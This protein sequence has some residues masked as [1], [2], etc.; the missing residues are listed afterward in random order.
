MLK[1]KFAVSAGVVFAYIWSSAW[2][3]VP[4]ARQHIFAANSPSSESYRGLVSYRKPPPDLE[5]SMDPVVGWREKEI[6]SR[7]AALLPVADEGK[8]TIEKFDEAREVIEMLSQRTSKKSAITVEHLLR[9]VVQEKIAGNRVVD[10]IDMKPMYDALIK[11]WA[12]SGEKGAA[13]RAEEILD[14]MQASYESGE[15]HL[16]PDMETFNLVLFAYS[17][18]K[19]KDTPRQAMRIL[20]K[21][22]DL[23]AEG[24]TD[25]IPNTES[26]S[27]V[28]KAYA[29]SSGPNA[30]LL[31][32]KLI[33][34]MEKLSD[35]GFPAVRPDFKCHNVYL[36]A[37]LASMTRDGGFSKKVP[38]KAEA[39]LDQMLQNEDEEARPDVWSWNMVIS[40]WSKSG[41][42]EMTDRAESLVSRIE[43]YHL[44]CGRSEK[45]LPNTNTYNCLIA[46][47][48]RS[49]IKDKASRAHAVLQKMKMLQ[50]EGN[51]NQR[52]DAV[53]YNSV[54]N[55]YAKSNDEEAPQKVEALLREMHTLYEETGDRW[56]KPSSRSFNSCVSKISRAPNNARKQSH[57][58]VVSLMLG[59]NQSIHK[60][61]RELWIGS[62]IC[63]SITTQ[64]RV[65]SLQINGH[66]MLIWRRFRKYEGHQSAMKLKRYLRQWTRNTGEGECT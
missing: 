55:A 45:T 59:Q 37:L 49:T 42:W 25:V 19:G 8:W 53:T 6:E 56:L 66:T 38:L 28:L 12:K 36:A 22:Q 43:A 1:R 57:N 30:A 9:R 20:Q 32:L 61:L 24:K 17:A 58:S 5:L 23:R 41:H 39:Y 4:V 63:S 40:A 48:G 34:R 33:Q 18:S 51:Y 16:K 65:K 52:P 62:S 35:E 50:A 26:Y 47:Y 10:S 27:I 14:N 29:S 46:C 64:G 2:C 13:Q 21:L 15:D 44:E 7:T 3:F 60:L 54:M 11:T 31:V